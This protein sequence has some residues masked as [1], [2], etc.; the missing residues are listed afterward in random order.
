MKKVQII[1]IV[2]V[3]PDSFSDGG[4][5][6]SPDAA[7]AHVEQLFQDGASLVDIGAES[8]RPGAVPLS[9]EE[10]WQRIAPILQEVLPRHAGLILLDS[11]HPETIER[12]ASAFG[13]IFHINDVT[14]FNDSRMVEVAA[15]YK[16]PAVVSHL[17][18][19]FATDIQRAHKGPLISDIQQVRTELLDRQAVLLAAGVPESAIILDPGIGFGKTPELNM[20]LLEFARFVP[21]HQV[22][23]GYSRKRFL[24]DNRFDTESN[25]AA[26]RI[27]VAA[28]AAYIR[29]HDVVVHRTLL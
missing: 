13:S 2:N 15:R 3:T 10:E 23:I 9:P 17:P 25:L 29:V 22:L 24:G 28:G 6:F 11:H 14:G 5:Y 1:G 16:L 4:L 7:V 20:A 19:Q 26:G 8:T 21:D 12:A 27:A 18:S